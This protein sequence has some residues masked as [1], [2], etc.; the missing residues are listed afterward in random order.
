M[1][2]SL[3][4]VKQAQNSLCPPGYRN[5][6]SLNHY[7]H[8]QTCVEQYGRCRGHK[9]STQDILSAIVA[10][11][12]EKYVYVRVYTHRHIKK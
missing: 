3:S 5:K 12:K 6:T 10:V 2:G 9:N 8:Q 4:K 11:G 7:C 1:V